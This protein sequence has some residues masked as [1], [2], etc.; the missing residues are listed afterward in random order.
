VV[1]ATVVVVG[2]VVIGVTWAI[3]DASSASSE[4][5]GTQDLGGNAGTTPTYAS[6]E[7]EELGI[8]SVPLNPDGTVT[9]Q[10]DEDGYWTGNYEVASTLDRINK[11]EELPFETPHDGE[12]F[13]NSVHGENVLPEQKEGYYTEYVVPDSDKSH[14]GNYRIV[15]GD[16]GEIYFSWGHYRGG[17]WVRI[18]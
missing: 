10:K 17:T 5:G 7:D 2:V 9:V 18:K 16:N 4:M 12:E 3:I 1:V 6:S 14:A 8:P 11:G 15:K 13:G